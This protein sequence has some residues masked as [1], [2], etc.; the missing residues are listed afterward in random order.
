MLALGCTKA[1]SL[2]RSDGQTPAYQLFGSDEDIFPIAVCGFRRHLNQDVTDIRVNLRQPEA[3]Q[4]IIVAI[5]E[6]EN[7]DPK[8]GE[9][10]VDMEY[11]GV[12][13]YTYT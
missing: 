8:G 2:H 13:G 12:E 5:L 4:G 10:N 11:V 9:V 1:R 6:V 7:T 3:I